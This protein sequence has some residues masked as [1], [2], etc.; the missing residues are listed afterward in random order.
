MEN[1]IYSYTYPPQEE[2]WIQKRHAIKGARLC[3]LMH[4]LCALLW[5]EWCEV[6]FLKGSENVL[7]PNTHVAI[8]K[9]QNR[10]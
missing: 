2:L 1:K 6:P 10:V 4:N 5:V 8:A 3:G 9:S 7:H